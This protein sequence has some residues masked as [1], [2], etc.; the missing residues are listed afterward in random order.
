MASFV[1]LLTGFTSSGFPP[2]A[3][4]ALLSLFACAAIA[5]DLGWLRIPLPEWRRQIP[6]SVFTRGTF[7]GTLQFGVELGTAARTYVSSSL[8]YLL[9]LALF[10]LSPEFVIALLAG[11]GF[12]LGRAIVPLQ[13]AIS[14][15]RQR[16]DLQMDD[17]HWVAPVSSLLG[18]PCIALA[19]LPL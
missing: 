1:W 17:A 16:W 10:L 4:I 3:A 5:R 14:K 15:D 2:L 8:P 18:I 7:F 9:A 6:R 12:G 11:I 19:G 13:R